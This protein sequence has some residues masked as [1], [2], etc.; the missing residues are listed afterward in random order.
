MDLLRKERRRL[1]RKFIR[2]FAG[3][4]Y[5]GIDR[6]I[7]FEYL[8]AGM[9]VWLALLVQGAGGWS[10]A[11]IPM[12]A[13]LAISVPWWIFITLVILQVYSRYGDKVYMSVTR[14]QLSREYRS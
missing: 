5:G 8:K 13:A 7:A 12:I 4:N 2:K 11:W 3:R 6:W 10:A 14:K 1:R 9:P